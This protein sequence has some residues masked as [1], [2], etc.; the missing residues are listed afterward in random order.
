[1]LKKLLLSATLFVAFSSAQAVN[2]DTTLNDGNAIATLLKVDSFDLMDIIL[3]RDDLV[4]SQKVLQGMLRAIR[5]DDISV[6]RV[7]Y[8]DVDGTPYETL[9]VQ[10]RKMPPSQPQT[11]VYGMAKFGG[12][13]PWYVNRITQKGEL[14]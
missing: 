10:S 9:F 12:F 13:S 8:T 5:A 1:M 6:S 4:S 14:Q 11:D 2:V 7:Y 3:N